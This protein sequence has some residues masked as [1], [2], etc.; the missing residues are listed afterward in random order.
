MFCI[1]VRVRGV[2]R[3]ILLAQSSEAWDLWS[4]DHITGLTVRILLRY[5]Q[6]QFHTTWVSFKITQLCQC[7]FYTCVWRIGDSKLTLGV[8]VCVNGHLSLVFGDLSRVY[9]PTPTPTPEGSWDR[10]QPPSEVKWHHRQN[11]FKGLQHLKRDSGAK[12]HDNLQNL[13]VFIIHNIHTF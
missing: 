7:M 13:F 5:S 11:I 9:P 6:F 2:D 3:V 12:I 10:L 1:S 4:I 8:K